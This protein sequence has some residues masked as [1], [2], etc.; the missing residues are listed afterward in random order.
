VKTYLQE[1][2]S[3]T[4]IYL[5][6]LNNAIYI[7]EHVGERNGVHTGRRY[8]PE[9]CVHMLNGSDDIRSVAGHPVRLANFTLFGNLKEPVSAAFVDLASTWIIR[10]GDSLHTN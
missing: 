6:V 3:V 5:Q 4:S 9:E 8:E 2:W 10:A 1:I 7:N